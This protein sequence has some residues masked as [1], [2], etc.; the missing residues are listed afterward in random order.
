M[1]RWREASTPEGGKDEIERAF[2]R[3]A[4]PS[5][6][7]SP[8]ETQRA[9][10]RAIEERLAVGT[11]PPA[12]DATSAHGHLPT[13]SFSSPSP[14]RKAR[15]LARPSV[16][17]LKLHTRYPSLVE[18]WD[19]AAPDWPTLLQLKG[20]RHTVPVPPHWR[21]KRKYLAN[22][23][24]LPDHSLAHLHQVVERLKQSLA[25]GEAVATRRAASYRLR[26]HGDVYQELDEYDPLRGCHHQPGVLSDALRQALG[27][28]VGVHAAV[29]PPWL[30][31]FARFGR[32]PAYP[33]MERAAAVA[34]ASR[35]AP[36]FPHWGAWSQP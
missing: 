10:D 1:Q 2:Q 27:M 21:Y 13:S 18:P 23:R 14:S 9:A 17:Q 16:L 20:T 8:A 32:P 19:A 25:A 28:P 33:Y 29:A 24:G 36:M 5:S 35:T 26:E 3:W 34:R 31:M 15:K 30:P 11:A 12:A 6:P 22:K 7:V 4:A